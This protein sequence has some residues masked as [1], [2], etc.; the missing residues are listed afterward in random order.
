MPIYKSNPD[1]AIYC[2]NC[3]DFIDF[4]EIV[5]DRPTKEKIKKVA[6]T[7]GWKFIGEK[8]YCPN[9]SKPIKYVESEK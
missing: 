8:C 6:K 5:I 7:R 9:C 4:G 3:T 2:N 1:Y